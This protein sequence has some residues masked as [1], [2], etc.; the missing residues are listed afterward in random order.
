MNPVFAD[1]SFYVATIN[2]RD[3]LREF[4]LSASDQCDGQYI[5]TEYVLVE[6]GNYFCSD[7]RDL[8]LKLVALIEDDP[9]TEVVPA[10]TRLFQ[11]GLNLYSS[12]PNKGWSLTDCLSFVVMEERGI[13]DALTSD[14]HFNQAGFHAL[15]RK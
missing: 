13:V 10:T 7:N 11:E 1:T 6:L 12:R 2:P 5:T 3:T 9:Y 8:F 15:L 14:H 4:A